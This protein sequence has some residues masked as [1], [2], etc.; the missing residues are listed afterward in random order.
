[1]PKTLVLFVFH[2]VNDRVKNFIN[3]CIFKDP[4]VDFIVISNNKRNKFT[5]PDYVKVLLRDNIGFDFGGW[6]DA[7]LTDNRYKNYENFVFINSST[8]GPFI[9]TYFKG[10]WTDIYINGLQDNVKL[11]GSTINTENGL[12]GV[13]DPALVSHVQTYVFS[14]DKTT[15]EYLIDCEIF[16]MTNYA[17]THMDAINKKE[18][19]MSR[20]IIENKW[21]IGSLYPDYKNVDFT[22]AEKKPSEYGINFFKGDIMFE[23]HRN[24]LWN[25][26]E[27]VFLKSTR[28]IPMGLISKIVDRRS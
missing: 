23:K 2:V 20:K 12:I 8:F 9:P 14:M 4:N 21:N 10:N 28:D 15:L 1:M 6:S 26:Y 3:N 25:E 19:L 17:I 13:F 22:F 5:V 11:F 18:I 16:S 7:L 27:L 24:K